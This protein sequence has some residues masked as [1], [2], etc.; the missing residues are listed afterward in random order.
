MKIL[1]LMSDFPDPP[2]GG[3]PLRI[4]GLLGGAADAGHEIHVLNFGTPQQAEKPS[5]LHELAANVQ[6]IPHPTRS[7]MDRIQTLLLSRRADMETRSLS[8]AFLIAL[9]KTLAES[10]FDIVQFQS[11]EM[12]TYLGF[13]RQKQPSARLIYDAYNAEAD[14]QRAVFLNDRRQ[15]KRWPL[16]VYSWMQWGRL[17]RYEARLC[18]HADAVIAVSDEDQQ[19]L[20]AVAGE[21]PVFLVN[22]AIYVDDYAQL[23]EK[24]VELESPSLVFTGIMDYR[25][26]VDAALW[27]ANDIFPQISG[28]HLYLV[29]NRPGPQVQALGENGNITVTGFV[30]EVLPYLHA[31]TVFAVPMRVGS[32]TRLKLLQA[33]AAGCAIVSTRTGAAGLN[34]THRREMLLADDADSFAKAVNE[35]LTDES[36]RAELSANGKKFVRKHFDWSVIV[37][38]LLAVYEAL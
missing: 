32:G 3:G 12:G 13:V 17:R 26:N 34:V 37:P 10:H 33:M 19:I 29:G 38:K 15:P 25:P 23:P 35:L 21:T 2:R 5:R 20:Q 9:E 7:K 31:A 4:M 36:R 1:Y 18:Q 28:A 6:V 24:T 11:L 14:M 27:F 22:N 8:D 30:D 16:A